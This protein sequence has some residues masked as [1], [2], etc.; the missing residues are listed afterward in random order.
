MKQLQ[1]KEELMCDI[2]EES[3]LSTCLEQEV[4]RAVSIISPITWME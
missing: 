1:V 2:N 4:T 3:L